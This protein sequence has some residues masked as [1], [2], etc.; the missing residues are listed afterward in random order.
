MERLNDFIK[1]YSFAIVRLRSDLLR[2]RV[3]L[4]IL[5]YDRHGITKPSRSIRLRQKKT[6]KCNCLWKIIV[7]S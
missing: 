4:C 5:V 2:Q 1:A 6:R 3:K 7:I